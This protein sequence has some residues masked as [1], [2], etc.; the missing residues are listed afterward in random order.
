MQEGMMPEKKSSILELDLQAA[1]EG[2]RLCT[3]LG[4]AWACKTLKVALTSGTLSP[5]KSQPLIVPLLMGP[6][7]QTR[8]S[9]GAT[10]IQITSVTKS[11]YSF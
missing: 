3:T 4:L 6:T 1:A 9:M 5:A 2:E 8:E 11:A 10:P 7:I